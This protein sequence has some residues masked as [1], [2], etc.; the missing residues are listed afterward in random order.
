MKKIIS[1]LSFPFKML[2]LGMIYFYKYCI[3]PILPNMCIYE[4][5]CSTYTLVAIKRFGVIKGVLL[6]A[7]R[8][9]RCSPKHCGC[10]DRVPDDLKGDFKWLI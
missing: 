8:I 1:I 9:W 4:P 10:V 2:F 5:T 7:K 6:G 3:S